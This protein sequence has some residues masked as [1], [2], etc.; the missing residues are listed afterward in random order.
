MAVFKTNLD[1]LYVNPPKKGGYLTQRLAFRNVE[2]SLFQ[3][4]RL[5]SPWNRSKTR[6]I[7]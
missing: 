5:F 3:L 4:H 7:V 6:Y 2:S 1:K